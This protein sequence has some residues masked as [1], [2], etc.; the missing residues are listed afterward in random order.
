[1]ENGQD[2]R[3][4]AEDPY[5]I[6]EVFALNNHNYVWRLEGE[7]KEGSLSFY[8]VFAGAFVR[9]GTDD[10]SKGGLVVVYPP[11]RDT[12]G[13]GDKALVDAKIWEKLC[14][15][16]SLPPTLEVRRSVSDGITWAQCKAIDD[17]GAEGVVCCAAYDSR[18]VVLLAPVGASTESFVGYLMPTTIPS[19]QRPG[20]LASYVPGVVTPNAY[21]NLFFGVRFAR[22]DGFKWRHL[23]KTYAILKGVARPFVYSTE[24][25]CY[26]SQSQEL[27][28]QVGEDAGNTERDEVEMF[29]QRYCTRISGKRHSITKRGQYTDTLDGRKVESAIV[30][31]TEPKEGR[32]V[33]VRIIT[34]KKGDYHMIITCTAESK[35]QVDAMLAQLSF[36]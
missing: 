23:P 8:N 4:P 35:T 25:S 31:S 36:L 27:T 9:P 18:S 10:E 28:I 11:E 21:T 29:L 26:V 34:L 1:M 2:K 14:A 33:V 17:A 7:T 22:H 30:C 6:G 19:S 3:P 5:Y 15:Y 13:I 24:M 32:A 20:A 16:D 12:R